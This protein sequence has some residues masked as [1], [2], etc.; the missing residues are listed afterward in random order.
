MGREHALLC[1][2]EGASVVVNDL[3][4]AKDGRGSSAEPARE[5]AEEIR[6]AGGEAVADTTSVTDF[7]GVGRMIQRAVESFGELH[8]VVNNA[9]F[10]RDRRVPNMTEEAWDDSIAVH[11]KGAFATTHFASR[12]WRDRAK[13]GTP[14]AAAIVNTISDAGTTCFGAQSAYGAAKAGLAAFTLICA[15]DLQRFGV[16]VNAVSPHARTR[17]TLETAI[18]TD[19]VSAE[20]PD[21]ELDPV[22]PVHVSTLVAHLA[23]ADCALNGAVIGVRG[24]TLRLYRG[25]SLADSLVRDEPWRLEELP[26]AL[27]N[28]SRPLPGD[29]VVSD[30]APPALVADPTT[31]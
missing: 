20:V 19:E 6:A 7:D 8:A 1:A 16:C 24:G 31:R 5:V 3:G 9:G 29:Q 13:A 28:W 10:L 14:V 25:W 18:S 15:K 2:R 4:G 12:H 22:D 21:G 30:G 27:Q 17:L 26:A 23:S 11:L